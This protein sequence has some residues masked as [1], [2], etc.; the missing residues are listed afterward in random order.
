M[1][2]GKHFLFKKHRIYVDFRLV[3]QNQIKIGGNALQRSKKLISEFNRSISLLYI[4][5]LDLC[6]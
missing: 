3:D 5:V 4:S 1:D 6:L 2:H